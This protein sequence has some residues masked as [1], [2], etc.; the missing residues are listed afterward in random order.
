[1]SLSVIRYL[2]SFWVGVDFILD[3]IVYRIV[4]VIWIIENVVNLLVLFVFFE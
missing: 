1:M 3:F 2:F 4:N